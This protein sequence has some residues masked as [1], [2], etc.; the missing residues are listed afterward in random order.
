ME[1]NCYVVN[2]DRFLEP[3]SDRPDARWPASDTPRWL[4]IQAAGSDKL[5]DLLMPLG[6]HPL[7]LKDCR[8]RRGV[9]RLEVFDRAMY[10]TLPMP[11]G[12]EDLRHTQ[13]RMIVLPMTLIT[14]HETFVPGLSAIAADCESETRLAATSIPALIHHI[15]AG[16]IE[17]DAQFYTRLRGRIDMIFGEIDESGE[18][19]DISEIIEMKRDA[20][21]LVG[22]CEDLLHVFNMLQT[23]ESKAF[24]PA[25]STQA[26][27]NRQS[28]GLERFHLTCIRIES[29]LK[30]LQQ[31]YHLSLQEAADN[32]LRVL[33][34]ISAVFLPLTFIAGIY[35]MN[36]QYMPELEGQYGYFTVLGAMLVVGLALLLFFYRCGWLK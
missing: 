6:L 16:L 4:D 12:W 5:D 8:D 34:I 1:L 36:F 24:Q 27:I 30:D 19:I 26:H 22:N 15:L 7:I 25:A 33:T 31:H 29:R 23:I 3:C 13:L 32:R 18:R 21:Q 17:T 20:A 14:V 11:I 10:L 2:S 9:A 35:G 28:K